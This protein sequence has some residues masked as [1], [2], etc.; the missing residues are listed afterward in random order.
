M[1][2]TDIAVAPGQNQ[3]KTN[4][5]LAVL[6]GV[7]TLTIFLSAGLLFLVQPMFGR[8][9]LPMLGGSP[10]VWNTTMVFYQ[11]VLL[12]G[13]GYAHLSTKW[14]GVKKQ[15]L[16]H[17]VL[18][19]LPLLVLP[20]AVP[21]GWTP[22]SDTNPAPWLLGLLMFAVGLPFFVVSASSPL[23]QKWFAATG[24]PQAK[25]PYFLY[26][27][28]N[29]GSLLALLSYPI[30]LEP[31]LRLLEQ[32]AL[33]RNL[34][35]A[36]IVCTLCSVWLLW[37][38]A[39]TASQTAA[40]EEAQRE[41]STRSAETTF[42]TM[43][44]NVPDN[45]PTNARRLNWVALSFV[46]SSLM[47]SVTTYLSTD[48][49]AVPLMWIVPLVLYLLTFI[50][51]FAQRQV[52]SRMLATRALALLVLPLVIA[53]A[54]RANHPIVLLVPLHLLV[55]FVITLVCHGQI[56][57]DRPSPRH[58]TEF[59][60]W[61][62]LGGVL[63]GAFNALLAPVLF[64]TVAEYPLTLVLA[65][66]LA[67]RPLATK[68]APEKAQ[69]HRVLDFALPVVLGLVTFALVTTL[70]KHLEA[71]P[72]TT[73]LLFGIPA[74]ACFVFSRRPLRYALGV[75]AILLA[76]TFYLNGQGRVINTARSFFG[77]HR[78]TFD[79]TGQLHQI[80]HGDTLHGSQR[81]LPRPEREP[82]AYYYRTGPLGQAFTSFQERGKN[83]KIAVVGLG[84]GGISS[85]A[86]RTQKWTFYEIDPV[87]EQLAR[88][89]R[90]F[91]YLRDCPAPLDV[92]LGDGR[93]TLS[94]AK[95]ASY[96]LLILDA[97]SSDSLPIHLL[98][99]QSMQIYLSKL[100]P[101]GVMIFNISNRHLNLAAVLGN[102]AQ[103]ANLVCLHQDQGGISS[104]EAARGKTA[105][106]FAVV[107]RNRADLGTLA[108]DKRWT[109]CPTDPK[110][111]VWT[112]DFASVFSVFQMS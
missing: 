39:Q 112:D 63:G 48:I 77:V 71:G 79:S 11:A 25:D 92:I 89:E 54:A 4:S 23:L 19:F 74:F 34:Y 15:A 41:S 99:R 42:E 109:P 111:G 33:W 65:C 56:A 2:E 69:L 57:D 88:D 29:A 37:R 40:Q 62:S 103:D 7:F 20:I 38:H 100:A 13:Y 5:S 14:L 1:S 78:V 55:F 44:E 43:L 67:L 91:T 9:V 68:V 105:S 80:V 8:M 102:I 58:L 110:I 47:M 90:F 72:E 3:A 83:W 35:F 64:S 70:Q 86:Q 82:Q 50:L 18:L 52:I 31:R 108:S 104:V 26:A 93:L 30:L 101:H 53:M 32:S 51:V 61:M 27:A 76:G 21:R 96:D 81:W 66:A 60:L 73:G 107:A 94:R 17:S 6:V 97:Y 59:Y 75:G 49:A 87:V 46:P 16:A 24:H 28:S 84:A 10:S 12:L 45:A 95:P 36:F 22:P 106:H 85:Y 98:T